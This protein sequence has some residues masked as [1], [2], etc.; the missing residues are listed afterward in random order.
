MTSVDVDVEQHSYC[1][2]TLA[3]QLRLDIIRILNERP[4][5]V[6]N[7]AKATG[8]ERSRVSHALQIL[9]Q[10]RLVDIEKQG[11]EIIYKLSNETPLF[12]QRRGNIFMLIEEHARTKCPT[13]V[14]YQQHHA[15]KHTRRV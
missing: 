4:S 11:R 13:C 8:A 3:N 5:N 15:K 12:K 9:R 2:E 10:C 1:F 6:T 14:K 7:L